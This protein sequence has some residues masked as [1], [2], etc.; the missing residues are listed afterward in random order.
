MSQRDKLKAAFGFKSKNN[1]ERRQS[2]SD[3]PS[4]GSVMSESELSDSET[5]AKR[6]EDDERNR[7]KS[8]DH[9]DRNSFDDNSSSVTRHSSISSKFG[10]KNKPSFGFKKKPS[11]PSSSSSSSIADPDKTPPAVSI[12][13]SPNTFN[14]LHGPG[15]THAQSAYIQRIL[16]AP[17]TNHHQGEDPLAKLR[18]AN[19]GEGIN[20]NQTATTTLTGLEESLKAFTSVEVLEGDN[21]FA[22][23]KC[24]KVKSG[25]YQHSHATVLEEDESVENLAPSITSSKTAPPSISIVGSDTASEASVPLPNSDGRLGRAGSSGS[26]FNSSIQ[27]APSPLRRLVEQ[28]QDPA[29]SAQTSY[30]ASAISADSGALADPEEELD[31]GLSDT[32]DSDD[33]PPPADLPVGVRPKMPNRRKS[34]HFVMR[35][36]F[37]RYLIAQSP[38][39]LVFH[40]KR[41]KQTN[42]SGLSFTSFYDLKKM[43]DFISFPEV[44]DLAPYLAPNRNDYK[45][46][47]TAHGP[48]APYMDW[49]SSEHGPDSQEPVMYRLYG[50]SSSRARGILG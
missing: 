37:K 43:D 48:R 12:P 15:P 7:R 16:S 46:A 9:D 27:R 41:F 28:D 42:K 25:K 2:G 21:A 49:P 11:R 17:P 8:M 35:R 39:V 5:R 14:R 22:C 6:N 26:R 4:T 31:D 29:Q 34:S 1:N 13:G 18:A 36:A 10:L 50:Q 47:P 40:F 20:V 23:R 44:F 32:S 24:W 33:E 30:A 19:A 45:L 38:E 3:A